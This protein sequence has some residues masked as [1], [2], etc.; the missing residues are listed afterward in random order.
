[1]NDRPPDSQRARP[2]QETGPQPTRQTSVESLAEWSTTSQVCAWFGIPRT[3]W[4][5]LR[6]RGETPHAYRLGSKELRYRKSDI[7]AWLKS[8][9]E[10]GG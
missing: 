3:S 4:Y 1:M 9:I 5:C 8:R 6:S 10:S 2:R 7:E